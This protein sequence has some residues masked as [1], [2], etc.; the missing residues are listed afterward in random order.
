ML[1]AE[2]LRH[3]FGAVRALD[4]ISF[5]LQAGQTLA[6]FGPNG[7]G[8]TTLLKVLAGLIQPRAGRAQIDGG[9]GAVG[10]IGHQPQLYG[11][12]TVRENLRFWGSLYDVPAAEQSRRETD[13]LA[14]LDLNAHATRPVRALSRGLVQ[15]VAIA[16]ALIHDPRVLLL[17]EPFTGLDR[18]AAEE[19]RRLLAEQAADGGGRVTVLVT[20]NVEEGTELA[21]DV[22]FMR[23]GRFA[24][25]APRAGRGAV[26]I[27]DAYRRAVTGG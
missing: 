2:G 27:A 5:T 14:R 20:H 16:R 17:D 12:L 24:E 8:K 26:A 11:H 6:V 3:S 9:R 21:T 7:A 15:R 23:A 25:L 13:L 19:F 22:A 10:W 18:T 4:D 1:L